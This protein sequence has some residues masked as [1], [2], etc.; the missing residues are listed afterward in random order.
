M[1]TLRFMPSRGVGLLVLVLLLAACGDSPTSG[2]SKIELTDSV[3][4]FGTAFPAEALTGTPSIEV[5]DATAKAALESAKPWASEGTELTPARID[6]N[7]AV[8]LILRSNGNPGVVTLRMGETGWSFYNSADECSDL[9][10]NS[11]LGP[12]TA[13]HWETVA[14]R[15]SFELNV[16]AV[17]A[18]CSSGQLGGDRLTFDVVE[19]SDVV[20]IVAVIEPVQGSVDCISNPPTPFVVELSEELGERSV[21]DSGAVP[22][23]VLGEYEGAN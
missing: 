18:S 3:S 5:D 20:E 7:E 4:C 12:T 11:N 1:F 13:V 23:R 6:S 22:V 19:S 10:R 9:R 8:V 15:S 21:V 17:E 2:S 14:D 16:V